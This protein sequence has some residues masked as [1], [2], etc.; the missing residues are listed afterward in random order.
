MHITYTKKNF[1]L[2][3]AINIVPLSSRS[4]CNVN[5]NLSQEDAREYQ[6]SLYEEADMYATIE[7]D[8]GKKEEKKISDSTDED[9]MMLNESYNT[10]H[11]HYPITDSQHKDTHTVEGN[12]MPELTTY[13]LRNEEDLRERSASTISNKNLVKEV[14]N[15]LYESIECPNGT[16]VFKNNAT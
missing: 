13:S 15:P 16:T 10:V 8:R 12:E 4:G 2:C 6:N 11:V 5:P 9:D 1:F 3:S 14:N 7:P